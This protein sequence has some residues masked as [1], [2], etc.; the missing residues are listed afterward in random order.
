MI[1]TT[2]NEVA[3]T[4]ARNSSKAYYS[5]YSRYTLPC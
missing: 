3:S 2:T 4:E 5:L 1:T